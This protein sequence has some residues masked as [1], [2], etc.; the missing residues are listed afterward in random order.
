MLV[1][2]VHVA[3]ILY[4]YCTFQDQITDQLGVDH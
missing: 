3:T 2:V 1:K 4:N